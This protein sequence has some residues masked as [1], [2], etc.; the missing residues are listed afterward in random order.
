MALLI[1]K[2]IKGIAKDWYVKIFASKGF[3]KGKTLQTY[4]YFSNEQ[5]AKNHEN[6]IEVGNINF[7]ATADVDIFKQGYEHLKT[8]EEF[9]NAIDC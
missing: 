6:A 2:E 1:N 4:G 9:K 5:K 3:N 8:T 7:V